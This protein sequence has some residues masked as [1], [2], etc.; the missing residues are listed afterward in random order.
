[1]PNSITT[2]LSGN[3]AYRN[4]GIIKAIGPH[5]ENIAVGKIEYEHF[6]D[7]S[8][9]YIISPFWDIVGGLP[10]SLFGGIPGINMDKRKKSYYRANYVPVFISERTPS[11]N[12]EDLWELLE[13]VGL[14]YYDQL[15]WLI[16]TPMRA[17]NDNL[18]VERMRDTKEIFEY[19]R[20]NNGI[21]RLQYDDEVV[22]ESLRDFGQTSGSFAINF[23]KVLTAG[24]DI[25]VLSENK[26]YSAAERT[27]LIP[28]VIE[29]FYI[30]T[31]ERKQLH[32]QGIQYAKHSGKYKGRP[33]AKVD[34]QKFRDAYLKFKTKQI[35]ILEAMRLAEVHSRS[36]F[37]RRVGELAL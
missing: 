5:G 11:K 24:A 31:R 12:R 35:N 28:L 9:Q 34:E 26:L 3:I 8:F 4:A 16:R 7:E 15:E 14:D 17:A 21:H 20:L 18:M 25:R 19:T 33:K 23:A 6:D 36:T 29:Q 10:S 37:Y 30:A 27:I 13:S 22:V 2:P 32:D 1:L